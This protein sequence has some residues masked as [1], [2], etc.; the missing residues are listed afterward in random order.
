MTIDK[1]MIEEFNIV[2]K[3][4]AGHEVLSVNQVALYGLRK[5]LDDMKMA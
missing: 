1:I 4:K 5:A 3:F 2:L